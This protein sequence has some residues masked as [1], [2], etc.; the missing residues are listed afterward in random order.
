VDHS[1]RIHLDIET[2]NISAE[3]D[4]L[5]KLGAIIFEEKEKWV[6]M[7]APT[8]HRFC[9]VNPQ[10]RDFNSSDQVNIWDK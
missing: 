5:K 8:G 9:V 4:R 6:V 1:S 3:V 2:D 7:E 10:R